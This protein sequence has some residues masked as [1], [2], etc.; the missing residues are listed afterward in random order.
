MHNLAQDYL[1]RHI[2]LRNDKDALQ[3][4][5]AHQLNNKTLQKYVTQKT[6][7]LVAGNIGKVKL[8]TILKACSRRLHYLTIDCRLLSRQDQMEICQCIAHLKLALKTVRLKN[9]QP[10]F[11]NCVVKQ[12]QKPSGLVIIE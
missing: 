2:S 8:L 12:I 10:D 3:L 6:R 5:R 11:V 7:S 9:A 4:I 1:F